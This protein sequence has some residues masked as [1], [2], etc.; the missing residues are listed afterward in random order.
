MNIAEAINKAK[1]ILISNNIKSP[2]LDTELLMSKVLN[3]SREEIILDSNKEI[4]EKILIE[5]NSL[6]IQR[7]KGKPIAYLIRKKNFWKNSFVVNENVLVPRPDTELIIE[8]V[9]RLLKNKKK[10]NVL[11]IGTGS[12]CIILSI[13][14]EKK[15][16]TGIGIDISQKCI[17]I[18]RTNAYNIGIKNRVKF[19]K[20]DVDNFNY[21]KY[22][23]IL[24]N[25]PYIKQAK[26]RCLEKDVIGFEP[27][28]ALDGGLD[29]L[30]V[31]RKVVKKSSELI[32][33]NGKL[34]LEIGF[35][36]KEK[37]KL[38]LKKEGYYINKILK[39]YAG[40]DRCIISTK[41]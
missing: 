2:E 22:D 30:S 5:F 27:K 3:K 23:L 38:I 40:H 28:I 6:V 20:S 29:G 24:S 39:D 12:G 21:G 17:N 15:E 13:L 41:K 1:K 8:E 32:K 14:D 33:N 36:Q 9:L 10:L 18:S 35:D 26:L 19:F 34:V 25:P 31:I 16:F 37:V 7:S 11:D 4:E